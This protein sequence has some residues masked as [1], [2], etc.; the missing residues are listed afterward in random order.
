MDKKL[1]L[2]AIVIFVVF[3]IVLIVLFVVAPLF[4]LG[5]FNPSTPRQCTFAG[6]FTCMAYKL[7]AGT[8][9]LDFVLGQETGH[10]IQITDIQ[11][12][13]G[14]PDYVNV[15]GYSP[16]PITIKSGASATVSGASTSH[17]VRCTD[18]TGNLPSH[19][20]AGSTYTGKLYI[21]YTEV[22]SEINRTTV[23]IF[24][25]VYEA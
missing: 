1:L 15:N 9:E 19:M 18:G 14:S 7:H 6:G 21:N 24:S 16:N 17:I 23:G 22:D 25:T 4:Y 8:G 11:C 12:T 10:T 3:C 20:T 2:V 13:Q 5:I